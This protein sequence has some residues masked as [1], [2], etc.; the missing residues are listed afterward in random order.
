MANENYSK[1]EIFQVFDAIFLKTFN[2]N[3]AKVMLPHF[4]TFPHF[5]T[6]LYVEIPKFEDDQERTQSETVP[7]YSQ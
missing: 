4:A 3:H 5:A 7:G 6:V 2:I 1:H